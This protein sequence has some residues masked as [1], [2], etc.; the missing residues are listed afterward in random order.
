MPALQRQAWKIVLCHFL[1]HLQRIEC[2]VYN[3]TKAKNMINTKKC[4]YLKEDNSC[5]MIR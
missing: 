1:N 3:D 2:F 4:G 5:S